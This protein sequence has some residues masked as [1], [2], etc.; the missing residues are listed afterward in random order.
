M[1]SG[2]VGV[3]LFYRYLRA[4][5]DSV[6]L[7]GGGGVLMNVEHKCMYAYNVYA[8]FDSLSI[9]YPHDPTFSVDSAGDAMEI[10]FTRPS[11]R[12]FSLAGHSSDPTGVK[13]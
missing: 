11:Q 10:M 8:G 5:F 13:P 7:G 9:L 3:S 2:Q 4:T 12:F 1:E 6:S